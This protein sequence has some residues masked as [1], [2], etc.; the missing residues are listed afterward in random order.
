[1][2]G[3]LPGATYYYRFV[4]Q[5]ALDGERASSRIARTRTAPAADADVP[6]RFA[7]VSC[8]DFNG[9]Y[10]N[11]Y[12]RLIAEDPDFV[13]HL[14]DYIYETSADPVF[15]QSTPE[16]SVTLT[17]IDGA[18]TLGAADSPY[19]A[20]RSLSNYRELYQT[21]RGDALLQRVHER[22]PMVVIWD[23]H[24]FADDAYGANATAT[25]GREDERDVQRRKNANQA[26]WEYMPARLRAGDAFEYDPD[27][28]WPGDLDIYRD[29]RWGANLHLVLTDL[30]QYRP[31]H[32]VPED[33]FP[34]SVVLREAALVERFGDVP[35]WAQP[36][37]NPTT[38]DGGAF[39][40][41]V[42]DALA[43]DG[44]DAALA[45]SDLTVDYVNALLLAQSEDAML[46]DD[47][48][49]PRGLAYVTLG[50][51]GRY[52]QIGSRYLTI[53]APYQALADARFE[54]S[55]GA[56]EDMMGAEQETW[57]LETMQQSDATWKVWGNEFCLVQRAVDLTD[58]GALP[59]AF[60]QQFLLS[61]EDWDGS[62]NKRDE[63]IE[64]LA[65]VGNVVAITG[66]IHAFFAGVPGSRGRAD[67][68]IVEFV[69][70]AISSA[71]YQTLLINQA[72][73]D[74]TLRE[75][76][77]AALALLVKD[78]LLDTE[79]AT[80]PHLVHADLDRHGFAMVAV[81][82][83]DLTTT[84]YSINKSFADEPIP[85]ADVATAFETSTFQVRDGAAVLYRDVE[86]AWERWDVETLSWVADE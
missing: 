55:A 12:E 25:D 84:F 51:S 26:W 40:A 13:V 59:P 39:L 11:P 56:S 73:S 81:T 76:G 42:T 72:N 75:V 67:A 53:Q 47:P 61:A 69:T 52:S 31:D 20:A 60:A 66:D 64:A 70:G 46:I 62:P 32:V 30:R 68:R 27:A 5:E 16:R 43:S 2:T 48:D 82:S 15:Q 36:Y 50:K 63:L 3:L 49:L 34:A 33:G 58:F 86:G 6:A 1:V 65:D 24:E 17:D 54:E 78:L 23:D 14:G 44:D 4:V 9:R 22:Y 18:I 71:P 77:A 74:P 38:Y 45:N 57:F 21:Y 7:F 28:A 8:Q 85:D 37:L 80:N 29:V 41:L 79:K 35:E 10:Y 19:Y 83:D